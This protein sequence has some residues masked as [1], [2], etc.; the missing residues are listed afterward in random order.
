MD[1]EITV[2]FVSLFGE[3]I[4]MHFEVKKIYIYFFLQQIES[5][6][7]SSFKPTEKLSNE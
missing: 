5:N 1:W 2:M 4:K 6:G 3:D 7:D